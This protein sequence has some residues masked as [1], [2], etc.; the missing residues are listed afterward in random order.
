MKFKQTRFQTAM[1]VIG[2]LVILGMITFV[3]IKWSQL[4]DRIPG[5]YN[6]RGEVDR[7]GSRGEILTV[8]IMGVFV[9]L[10][11]AVISFFPGSWNLPV[12]ITET[13][14]QNLYECTRNLLITLKVEILI[15]FFYLTYNIA[16][17]KKL[18]LSFMPIFLLVLFGTVTYFIG[19]MYKI[20]KEK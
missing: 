16:A 2:L 7:W 8:P 18:A 6:I 12:N 13:N 5:H 17:A 11:L 14:R 20:G 19:R 10:L 1:E 4:P 15:I 3:C 9:Y